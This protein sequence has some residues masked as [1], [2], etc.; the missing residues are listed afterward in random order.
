MWPREIDLL[1]ECKAAKREKKPTMLWFNSIYK[2]DCLKKLNGFIEIFY[3]SSKKVSSCFLKDG[4]S[5][6]NEVK[7]NSESDVH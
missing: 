6:I 3:K 4:N 1:C 5:K 7:L 2:V